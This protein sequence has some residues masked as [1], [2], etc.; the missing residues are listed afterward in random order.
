MVVQLVASLLEL[1]QLGAVIDRRR[2]PVCDESVADRLRESLPRANAAVQI[3]DEIPELLLLETPQDGVD[4]GALLSD[5][6]DPLIAS[7]K[8]PTKFAIV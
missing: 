3:E 4:R 1:L 8:P 6:Q 5:E 7:D 2:V